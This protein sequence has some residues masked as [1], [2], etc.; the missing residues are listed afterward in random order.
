MRYNPET[1]RYDG[2]DE[3]TVNATA[4]IVVGVLLAIVILIGYG[5]HKLIK[6]NLITIW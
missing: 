3:T 5:V 4:V 6:Y 1:D 2:E